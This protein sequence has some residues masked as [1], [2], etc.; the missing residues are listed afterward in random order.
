MNKFVNKKKFYIFL[1]IFLC[2]LALIG[3]FFTIKIIKNINFSI[4]A[5]NNN[6]SSSNNN[7]N[8]SFNS[9]SLSVESSIVI[10]KYETYKFSYSAENLSNYSII[11]K[12][13]DN[14]IAS[15]DDELNI[16]PLLVGKTTIITSINCHPKIEKKTTLIIDDAVTDFTYKIL[17]LNNHDAY[18]YVNNFYF[19][20]ITENAIVTTLPNIIYDN[21]FISGFEFISK[22]KNI[23]TYKFKVINAGEFNFNYINKYCEKYTKNISAYNYPS[24]YEVNFDISSTNNTLNLY[25]FNKNF[26][27]QANEDGYFNSCS[28]LL[29]LVDNSNEIIN[30]TKNNDIIAIDDNIITAIE[31]GECILT[32]TSEITDI[33]KQY[34]IF[35]QTIIVNEINYNNETYN[36]NNQ[37]DLTLE[38]N[39]E[40]DFIIKILPIY[41]YGDVSIDYSD[42]VIIKN[43]KI[44]LVSNENQIINV[45]YNNKII[46]QFNIVSLKEITIEVSLFECTTNCNFNLDKI[47]ITY[48]ND[49]FLILKCEIYYNNSL[50]FNQNLNISYTS[51]IIATSDNSSTIKNNFVT[52]E[53]L[54]KGSC[55]IEIFNRNLNISKTITIIIV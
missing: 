55:T 6:D 12:I 14:E 26:S 46:L 27:T 19:L 18:T 53:I 20:E 11:V 35:V 41:F 43:N 54:E 10:D 28:F 37:I 16:T 52:L 32:F 24:N 33:K 13:M 15:I 25:I 17:D 48:S 51:S 7:E 50:Y 9:P 29:T 4:D 34:T 23:L 45:I 21:N 44:K 2:F 31:D 42:G 1:I 8:S 22:N 36:L 40:K 47:T 5:N 49:C 3:T 38:L 30:I 39:Q